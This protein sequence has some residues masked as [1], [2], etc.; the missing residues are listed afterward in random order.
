LDK[1]ELPSDYAA[2]LKM[3]GIT[4]GEL[5]RFL[6]AYYGPEVDL[7]T[8]RKDW[9]EKAKAGAIIRE[10]VDKWSRQMPEGATS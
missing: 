9:I 3:R 8:A 7:R 2:I 10:G 6:R 4:D 5:D 1:A